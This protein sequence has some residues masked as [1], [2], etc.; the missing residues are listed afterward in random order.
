VRPDPTRVFRAL[1]GEAVRDAIRRRVVSAI[2]VV[3]LL[4]LV[5][6]DG[7]TAC[8][9]PTIVQNGAAVQLPEVAGWTGMVIF[10]VLGLWAM[11]LAGVLASDHLAEPLSDGSA[12]LVLARPVGRSTFALARLVGVL[13]IAFATATVLL[14]GSTVML[15]ARNGV[16]VGGAVWGLLACAGGAV[17]VASLAMTA[18]LYL[19]R[20]GTLF[21]VL[22]AVGVIAGIN[23]IALFGTELGGI[24]FVIDRF[25]PPLGSALVAAVGGWIAPAEVPVDPFA[26]AIRT[27]AW[28]VAGVSLLVVAF[29]GRD[30]ADD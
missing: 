5:I 27:A 14:G 28:A 11:V 6:V 23:A 15:H 26:I 10:A 17:T 4:S 19:P 20:V 25:G 30:I 8:G 24:A 2:A 12:V 13:A 16:A 3:S 9:A 1:A 29:R 7:C 22:A 18:S 21:A